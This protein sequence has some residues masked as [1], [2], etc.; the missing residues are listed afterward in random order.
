MSTFQRRYFEVA[1]EA[2][3]RS[4][5]CGQAVETVTPVCTLLRDKPV[6]KGVSSACFTL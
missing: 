4:A 3:F 5:I 2:F 1:G 6:C